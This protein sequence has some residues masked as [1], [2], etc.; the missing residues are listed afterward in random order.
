MARNKVGGTSLTH[1]QVK[2]FPALPPSGYTPGALAP[3]GYT[4]G[5]LPIIV[6]RGMVFRHQPIKMTGAT[7]RLP[8]LTCCEQCQQ[9]VNLIT[10][11]QPKY[12][13]LGLQAL[14]LR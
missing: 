9:A 2:Q 3:S 11:T 5:A 12:M 13:L 1:H 6:C 8:E 7:M 10:A 4:P 14:P